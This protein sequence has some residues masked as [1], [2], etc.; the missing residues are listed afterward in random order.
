[1]ERVHDYCKYMPK[2]NVLEDLYTN[3]EFSLVDLPLVVDESFGLISVQGSPDRL[4]CRPIGLNGSEIFK[5]LST[6]FE[7]FRSWANLVRGP[8]LTAWSW[9][10]KFWSVD[11]DKTESKK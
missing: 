8:G 6:A 2:D 4:V 9:A 10:G 5:I 7:G 11:L 1:M 3:E